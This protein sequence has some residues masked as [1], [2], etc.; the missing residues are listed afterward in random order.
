MMVILKL[1]SVW[2]RKDNKQYFRSRYKLCC[3]R[4]YALLGK[5]GVKRIDLYIPEYNQGHHGRRMKTI[6]MAYAY[7]TT[8][9]V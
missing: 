8:D 2:D 5:V 3:E 6:Y 4:V 7:F 1:D 9:M